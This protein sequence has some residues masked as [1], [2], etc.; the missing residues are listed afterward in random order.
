MAELYLNQSRPVFGQNGGIEAG[1]KVYFY[2]SGGLTET[3][4]YTTSGLTAEHPH[5][6]VANA[7]GIFPDI[8]LDTGNIT[9]RAILK[10][11]AGVTLSDID[12]YYAGDLNEVIAA[13]VAAAETA[14]AAAETAEAGAEAARDTALALAGPLAPVTRTT[15]RPKRWTAPTGMNN[16]L[17]V[18]VDCDGRT[19]SFNKRPYELTDWTE[20]VAPAK[21]IYVSWATGNDAN[22]GSTTILAVKSFQ[23]AMTLLVDKTVIHMMD[24]R[25]GYNGFFSGGPTF[26]TN[27]VK[28]IG[29]NVGGPTLFYSWSE[30][31]T[32]AYCSWVAD[33]AAFKTTASVNGA[34]VQAMFDESH[35]DAYGLPLA[36]PHVADLATVKATPGSWNWDGT[37]LSVHMVDGRTP[38][39]D[40]GWIPVTAFSNFQST[41]AADLAIE[42]CSF[43]YNG[44]AAAVAALRIRP[45]STG[46]P[47]T[48]RL[49]LKNVRAFGAS[50]NSFEL[51]DFEV[52]ALQECY[53][54][55]SYYDIFNY[56]S[57]IS[58]GT[59]G[60]WITVYEDNCF[61][62]DAGYS[63][64]QN[65]TASSS[66]NISTPHLGIHMWRV[67]LG[68]YNCPNS[69]IAE[70]QGCYSMSFGVRPTQST[71]GGLFQYNYWSQRLVGE[72]SAN[73]KMIL[74]G[75]S[76]DA[77]DA[78]KYEFSNYDDADTV[79]SLQE[80]HVADWL[81]SGGAAARGATVLKN[82]DSGAVLS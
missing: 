23:Q 75:C 60:Q 72:G 35:N 50:S 81:G 20:T 21:H 4:S 34:T 59:Q 14:R 55:H 79:V 27:R 24:R 51:Y 33:G 46:S 10:D 18:W 15:P 47:N 17:G 68:G 7:A 65:P 26:S 54:A 48:L 12:P 37:T 1:A 73:A 36:M 64:R 78:G 58:G 13:Q 70:V 45:A 66:N 53:G 16:P 69:F 76:G 32:A 67:N 61:G 42:N 3:P 44:G 30:T 43:A 2:I 77:P 80:I 28:I 62:H 74:I 22:D 40:D 25:V 56:K 8:Y 71:S 31:Y 82:Y 11:A 41:T 5:P 57:F 39:P 63:W 19:Y 6:V 29:E 38:D 49:A 9:Y 52:M